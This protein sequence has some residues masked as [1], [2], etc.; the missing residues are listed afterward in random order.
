ML[1]SATI[2]S[3]VGC[4][5]FEQQPASR[6][7]IERVP[8]VARARLPV[9]QVSFAPRPLE[10]IERRPHHRP[11]A[12][13]ETARQL[14]TEARLARRGQPVD[15]DSQPMIA[16]RV[17]HLDEP[18]EHLGS[19]GTG[20]RR[21]RLL[22]RRNRELDVRL[23]HPRQVLTRAGPQPA[24]VRR[25]PLV[26]PHDDRLREHRRRAQGHVV[27]RRDRAPVRLGR[28]EAVHADRRG[29]CEA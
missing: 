28:R 15:R 12:S 11:A 10:V 26:G 7:A 13:G 18:V 24:R 2:P 21:H 9:V 6:F 29:V 22:P 1:H 23:T 8:V 19:L 27:A 5:R 3:A 17:D 16:E 4:R 25:F 14:V 20:P